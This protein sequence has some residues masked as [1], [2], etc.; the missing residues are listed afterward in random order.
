LPESSKLCHSLTPFTDDTTKDDRTALPLA[1]RPPLSYSQGAYRVGQLIPVALSPK[2]IASS[3]VT[4][5]RSSSSPIL[6]ATACDEVVDKRSRNVRT[7]AHLCA[8]LRTF[9]HNV[10]TAAHKGS[11]LRTPLKISVHQRKTEKV[12]DRELSP[13]RIFCH[14]V[15]QQSKVGVGLAWNTGCPSS[16]CRISPSALA[17]PKSQTKPCSTVAVASADYCLHIMR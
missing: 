5:N 4:V 7:S 8:H 13:T 12:N 1:I 9:A 2:R 17:T 14:D 11:H 10:L 6:T 3:S 16:Q 15:S